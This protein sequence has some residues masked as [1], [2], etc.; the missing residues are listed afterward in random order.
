MRHKIE[1]RKDYTANFKKAAVQLVGRTGRPVEQV[2]AELGLRATDLQEWRKQF[3]AA[4]R[5]TETT[6]SIL[7][8][9][10][11]AMEL[12]LLA[13]KTEWD[14]L[15]TTLCLLCPTVQTV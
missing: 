6:A 5:K 12:Q 13:M 14:V 8:A 11:R 9:R 7:K 1:S 3:A 2:A 10:N 15:K 4:S